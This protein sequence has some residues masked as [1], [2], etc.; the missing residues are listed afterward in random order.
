MTYAPDFSEST[1]AVMHWSTHFFLYADDK[2]II[3]NS[4]PG[5]LLQKWRRGLYTMATRFDPS[6]HRRLFGD[7][8][9]PRREVL[10]LLIEVDPITGKESERYPDAYP[11]QYRKIVGR[12]YLAED[13]GRHFHRIL[14]RRPQ[15]GW[16]MPMKCPVSPISTEPN[17]QLFILDG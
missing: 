16:S 5:P 10:Y 4:A 15:R 6:T 7:L 2:G 13:H 11:K 17:P 14:Q 8:G 12:L 3:L 1:L 9:L